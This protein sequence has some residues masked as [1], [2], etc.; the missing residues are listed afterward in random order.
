MDL[1]KYCQKA[2]ALGAAEAKIIAAKDV[3]TANWVRL[4]CQYGCG[5]YGTCL[6]CPPYSP[7]P[8]YTRKML[9]DYSHGLLIT[10]RVEPGEDEDQMLE[11]LRRAVASLER[12]IFLNGGY[13]A[14]G[15]AAGPCDFCEECDVTKPC[16]FPHLARPSMEA[17]G[18]DV[19]ATV[20]KAGVKLE[21]V[22][23]YDMPCTYCGLILVGDKNNHANR[24]RVRVKIWRCN[25][26]KEKS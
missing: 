20:R 13:D 21:V 3:V 9:E 24:G 5:A 14:F 7:T 2:L 15:M 23:S 6:T 16:K 1:T 8:E 25:R 26:W 18:I 10:Y 11:N 17:C 4:K 22:R 19:F 12:D